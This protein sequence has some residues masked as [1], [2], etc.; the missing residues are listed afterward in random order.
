MDWAGVSAQLT[1]MEV[2]HLEVRTTRMLRGKSKDQRM[3]PRGATPLLL[4]SWKRALHQSCGVTCN[5]KG[6]RGGSAQG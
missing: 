1:R 6:K 4:P 3:P 2:P 5:A